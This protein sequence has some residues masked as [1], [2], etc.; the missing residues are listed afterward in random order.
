ML[1]SR[2]SA[3]VILHCAQNLRE[4]QS[5]TCCSQTRSLGQRNTFGGRRRRTHARLAAQPTVCVTGVSEKNFEQEVIKV[6]ILQ[7]AGR[8]ERF[9]WLFMAQMY[10]PVI[11]IFGV[12]DTLQVQMVH[13]NYLQFKPETVAGKGESCACRLLGDLVW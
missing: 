11:C 7:Q 12:N 6:C 5:R 4:T 8:S 1:A 13:H 10:S 2:T 9:Q 3:K